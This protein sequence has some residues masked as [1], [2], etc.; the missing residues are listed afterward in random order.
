MFVKY[1]ENMKFFKYIQKTCRFE[2]R[3]VNSNPLVPLHLRMSVT[4]TMTLTMPAMATA[5]VFPRPA[6]SFARA[7][8][9]VVANFSPWEQIVVCLLE[10]KMAYAAQR[11][12]AFVSSQLLACAA[13]KKL[14]S[15]MGPARAS[16][17]GIFYML[18]ALCLDPLYVC[19]I[20]P[21]PHDSKTMELRDRCMAWASDWELRC[22]RYLRTL[23]PKVVEA[24]EYRLRTGTVTGKNRNLIKRMVQHG[25]L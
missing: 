5:P 1:V 22:I 12:E 23:S 19:T 8:C 21:P 9:R 20:N 25:W 10:A 11:H 6:A 15:R 3:M 16:L 14:Q 18:E 13:L 7:C 2:R 17:R 24:F 4:E